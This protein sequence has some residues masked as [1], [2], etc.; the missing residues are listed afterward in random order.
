VS[1]SSLRFSW[2]DELANADLERTELGV[3]PSTQKSVGQRLSRYMNDDGEAWPGVARLA[4]ETS[5]TDRA[6]ERA[7]TALVANGLLEIVDRGGSGAGDT[8]RYRA[9]LPAK[10]ANALRPSRANQ[11]PRRANVDPDKGEPPSLEDVREDEEQVVVDD[12]EEP[13]EFARLVARLGPATANQRREWLDAWGESSDG[14][15]SVVEN[16]RG[17]RPA[18]VVSKQIR[19][20]AHRTKRAA[21]RDRLR[22]F[23]EHVGHELDERALREELAERG[24]A[25]GDLD[26]LLALASGRRLAEQNGAARPFVPRSPTT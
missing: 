5:F 22:R 11:D 3:A 17:D 20:G 21:D 7:L 18:G 13:I 24:A 1:G 15:A 19:D 14:F 12:V 23:V 25:E 8:A 9:L 10:R 16:A 6:V 4:R 26:E 2:R